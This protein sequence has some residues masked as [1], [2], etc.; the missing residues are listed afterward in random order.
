[1][2]FMG[3]CFYLGSFLVILRLKL[4]NFMVDKQ[5]LRQTASAGAGPATILVTGTG[6]FCDFVKPFMNLVPYFFFAALLITGY[7]WFFVV[8]KKL[9]DQGVDAILGSFYGKVFGISLI[10]TV[11]FLAAVPIFA[12]TPTQGLAASVSP[13]L[14]SLQESI[15]GRLDVMEKKIDAGF[16]K[17]LTKIDQID[18]GAGLIS[19]PKTSNDHYHNAR[20]HEMN[21][22]LMEAKKAYEEYFKNKLM[23]V[24]PYLSYSLI[25][26]NLEG[27]SGARELMGKLRETYYDLPPANLA[28]ILTKER[29]D[30][31]IQLLTDLAARFPDYGPIYFYIAEQYSYKESGLPTNEERRKERDAF[32]KLLELEETQKFSGF[33]IDKKLAEE[34]MNTVNTEM[35][36]MEGTIGKLIDEPVSFKVELVNKSASLV[37]VPTELVQKI[38]YRLDKKGEFKDTGSS[39]ITMAGYDG[40]LPNYQVM[41]PMTLGDHTLEMKYVDNKGKESPVYE[42]KFTVEQMKIQSPPYKMIDAKTGKE[43]YMIFWSFFDGDKQYKVK[44]SVDS[45]DLDKEVGYS[46]NLTDLAKGKHTI[47]M[48]GLEQDENGKLTGGKTNVARMEFEVM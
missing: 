43:Q 12:L 17:V 48:Q 40:F 31:R 11:F 1:M 15:F 34:N 38:F 9:K 24:D 45:A 33:F 14:A 39:G 10:A 16:E 8:N 6:F 46:L 41:E 13:D 18:A 28:Y 20:V 37:F 26:K 36:L 19:N 32:E 44:Y 21:G 27:V 23:Y 22:N 5:F 47:Y 42:H 30:D 35:K 2:S 3:F 25:L 4:L 29:R 7:L